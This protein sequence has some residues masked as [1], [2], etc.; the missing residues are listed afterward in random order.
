MSTTARRKLAGK[1]RARGRLPRSTRVLQAE[2]AI[3]FKKFLKLAGQSRDRNGL[4]IAAG[5]FDY[6]EEGVFRGTLEDLRIMPVGLPWLLLTSELL[7]TIAAGELDAAG[8]RSALEGFR[9]RM[10]PIWKTAL[11]SKGIAQVWL[12]RPHDPDF[13][14]ELQFLARAVERWRALTK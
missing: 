8:A 1:R 5:A 6:V 9:G 13:K 14:I 12:T 11:E 2:Q 7:D 4:A 10:T 3:P